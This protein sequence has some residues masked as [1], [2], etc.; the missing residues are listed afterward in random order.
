[1]DPISLKI[2]Q[3]QKSVSDVA[4]VGGFRAILIAWVGVQLANI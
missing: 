4:Y 2:E 3:L 1:M